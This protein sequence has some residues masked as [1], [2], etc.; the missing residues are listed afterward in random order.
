MSNIDAW[1]IVP[2]PAFSPPHPS[3][4]KGACGEEGEGEVV[5]YLPDPIFMTFHPSQLMPFLLCL[6]STV[7]PEKEKA[8][9]PSPTPFWPIYKSLNGISKWLYI[10]TGGWQSEIVVFFQRIWLP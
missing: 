1:L 6:V 9:L 3:A 4:I 8:A 10:R 2:Q 7:L 5:K